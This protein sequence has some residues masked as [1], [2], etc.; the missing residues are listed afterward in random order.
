VEGNARVDLAF[1]A[2]DI[3]DLLKSMVLQ[4]LGGGHVAAVS[5]D[6]HDPIDKTLK[7]FAIN[8]TTN[9][10]LAQILDQARGEKVEVV[11][12]QTNATQPGTLTGT[13]IGCEK[14]K[15][16]SMGNYELMICHRNEFDWG[17]DIIGRL[18][19]YTLDA[20]IKLGDT[21][22]I[23]SATPDEATVQALL[24]DNYATF[25]VLGQPAGLMLCIG[26]TEGELAHSRSEG[27]ASLIQSLKAGNVYPFTDLY[28]ASIV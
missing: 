20:V 8:L 5:Y 13:L 10:T 6:S 15:Q 3:N 24:F 23:G 4:D 17:H 1:P 22:D 27:S 21:M 7:S 28:R 19:F 26:I 9:P 12:Q 2:Q 25:E 11:L 14:Q 18:A 16:N